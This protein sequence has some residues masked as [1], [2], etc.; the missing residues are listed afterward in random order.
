M[1][2]YWLCVYHSHEIY[3]CIYIYIYNVFI[4]FYAL[5]CTDESVHTEKNI[6]E[7]KYNL[8]CLEFTFALKILDKIIIF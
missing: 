4:I 3:V 5:N 6:F 1:F 2:F 7:F 8:M